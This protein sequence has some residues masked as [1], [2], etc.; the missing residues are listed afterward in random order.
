MENNNIEIS[1]KDAKEKI[2]SE[3]LFVDV[4]EEDE[5]RDLSYDISNI[6]NIPLS[7]FEKRFCELPKYKELIIVCRS[8]NRSLYVT[9]F[10]INQGYT[11]A[12]NMQGGILEW[13][14]EGLPTKSA[15]S[16]N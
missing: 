11:H 7:Q 5:L 9:N 3:V 10:L 8:G 12:V 1:A 6:I 16:I 14:E 13:I 15:N 2:N 4:R